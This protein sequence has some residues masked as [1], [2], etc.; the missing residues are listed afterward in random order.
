MPQLFGI[1]D[2]VIVVIIIIIK[3]YILP[4][5]GELKVA[6]M[7]ISL[8]FIPTAATLVWITVDLAPPQC[9]WF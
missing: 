9:P 7:E 1:L 8:H 3:I 2:I 5:F 4:F 6:H